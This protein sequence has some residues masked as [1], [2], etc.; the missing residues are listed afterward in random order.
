MRAS[1]RLRIK[2]II[3]GLMPKFLKVKFVEFLYA[4][5][6][7]RKLNWNKLEAYTEKMQW[8]KLYD[9]TPIKTRLSDK[10][11]VRDW[12]KDKIGEKY[13]IPL[14]GVWD[15]Y[16][17]INFEEL[18]NQFVLKTN[19]GSGTVVIVKDKKTM[20]TKE[21]EKLFK[22]WMKT[23]YAYAMG[24]EMQYSKIDRKIIAEQYLETEYG[25]LQDYKFL[26]FNG[27]PYFCWVDMGRFSTHTRNVYDLNWNLL[28]WNQHLYGNYKEPLPRPK[29]FDTMVKIASTLCQGFDHVRV[30]LYNVNGD[31]YFGEMTFSNGSGFD[32]IV[33]DK[34][35]YELGKLWNIT[36]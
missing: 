24:C 21:S 16:D 10:Y 3:I 35:D 25:E 9:A 28:P 15:T 6:I 32:R 33:P 13:L 4:R 20:N 5:A 30:D 26:C 1:K 27:K 34:Y 17:E 18:P 23:D 19:H 14:L 8:V 2:A 29:N 36:T 12:V 31:I 22:D 7:G 11:L